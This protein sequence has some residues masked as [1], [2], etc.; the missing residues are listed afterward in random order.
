M[1]G[2]QQCSPVKAV[3]ALLARAAEHIAYISSHAGLSH[4]ASDDQHV[5]EL[6]RANLTLIDQPLLASIVKLL[7]CRQVRQH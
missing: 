3:C 1:G 4:D 5:F 2:F 6:L 7:L